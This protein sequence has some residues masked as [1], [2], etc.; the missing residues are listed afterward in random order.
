VNR[1]YRLST[2]VRT[3]A[4]WGHNGELL[5]LVADGEETDPLA[6]LDVPEGGEPLTREQIDEHVAALDADAL[7]ALVDAAR[8]E[9]EGIDV[10][11]V[12]SE[13]VD[14]INALG[15]A[16]EA[17]S[18]RQEAI[19]TE[20][21]ERQQRAADALARLRGPNGDDED[22]E[23]N[24]DGENGEEGG[25]GSGE[26]Q[27]SG[28]HAPE[29]VAA[30]APARRARRLTTALPR[31][32][33]TGGG[34]GSG[35]DNPGNRSAGTYTAPRATNALVAT[36]GLDSV[37]LTTGATIEHA[38]QLGD[39]F[40]VRLDAIRRGHGRGADGEHVPVATVRTT[41]PDGRRLRQN[42][43]DEN[44][45]VIR[46][47]TS[48]DALVA[49]GQ[50]AQQN[51]AIV[52]AGGLCGP[53][54]T[55]NDVP[56]LGSTARPVRDALANFG[57]DRGGV[58]WREH[59]SFG[60]FADAIGFW[61]MQNDEDSA[62][63][64]AAATTEAPY[65]GPEKPCAAVECPDEAEAFVEAITLCLLFRNVSA[66][67]DPEG[68][69][70]N[71]AAAQVA[72]ARV[73]ENRLLS[74]IAALSTT[75]TAGEVLGTTRDLL[76]FLDNLFAQYRSFYR[77]DD[78]I[79]F[80]QVLP[81]WVRRA[82]L[83]DLTRGM[84][85]DL[86]AISVAEATILGWFQRRGVNVT[87]SLDGLGSRTAVPGVA[88][89]IPA[90][91]YGAFTPGGAVA[92]YP[93]AIETFLWVEGDMLHLDGGTLDLGVVR[94]SSLNQT[95]EYKTFS[96]SWE[97]VAHRGVEAIRGVVTTRPIGQVAGTADTAAILAA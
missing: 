70:A 26:Q 82:M 3:R 18:A 29:P 5:A 58:R 72:H 45:S 63:A 34:M 79:A 39:A 93:A 77:L 31:P 80:R 52:A 69:A 81:E 54:E 43:I 97:G 23:E 44:T 4:A 32:G 76:T 49:A 55:L 40:G 47:A 37:G 64:R 87:W 6:F 67:F 90:Q 16:V 42:R 30:S 62:A 12:T 27:P 85:G 24:G 84:S 14:R 71:I 36:A 59:V 53:I 15:D 33:A 66:R 11:T 61:T 38:R 25:E 57:A 94:D 74:Q 68:T 96:E 78:S 88:P 7:Q 41:Y 91:V 22:G 48:R 50:A 10:A 51:G 1:P 73:A 35:T 95:N 2:A 13:D 28:E 89:A 65:A 56:V 75:V 9:A 20:E 83:S 46:E 60:D 86:D 92:P 21:Q 8:A 17:A 19:A